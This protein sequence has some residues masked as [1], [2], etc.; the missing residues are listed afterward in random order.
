MPK[1]L[2]NDEAWRVAAQFGTYFSTVS[3]QLTHPHFPR[4]LFDINVFFDDAI[5][6]KRPELLNRG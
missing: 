1:T 6:L 3:L 4:P 2:T 5:R